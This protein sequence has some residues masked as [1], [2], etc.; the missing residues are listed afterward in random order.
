MFY[1]FGMVFSFVLNYLYVKILR[2]D[3]DKL[4]V[5]IILSLFSWFG[6]FMA[7]LGITVELINKE[8]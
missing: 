8:K 5:L 2:K 6:V 1:L 4:E 7:I 3:M